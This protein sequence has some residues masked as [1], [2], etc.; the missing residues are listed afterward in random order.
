MGLILK[1]KGLLGAVWAFTGL[2]KFLAVAKWLP[3]L[4]PVAG[5][6]SAVLGFLALVARKTIEGITI[7][8]ANPATF[9]VAGLVGMSAFAFGV[10]HGGQKG[11]E[12]VAVLV[13]ERNEAHAEAEKRLAEALAAQKAAEEAAQEA[14]KEAADVSAMAQRRVDAANARARRMRDKPAETSSNGFCLPGFQ[15]LFPGCQT[16]GLK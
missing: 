10:I 14:T 6:A 3:G 7:M 2:S 8:F 9:V 1:L 5:I 16:S 13:N 15:A 11:A 12:R 4:G